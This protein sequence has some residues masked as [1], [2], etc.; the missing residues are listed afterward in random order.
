[1]N[2]PRNG[3]FFTKARLAGCNAISCIPIAIVLFV[4][5]SCA[6]RTTSDLSRHLAT[7]SA[8]EEL[9]VTVKRLGIAR[10]RP[11]CGKAFF[12][13]QAMEGTVCLRTGSVYKGG[14]AE[15]AWNKDN[16]NFCISAD[17]TQHVAKTP[18]F[19]G[20]QE[21]FLGGLLQMATNAAVG[22][23]G[24]HWS[25]AIDETGITFASQL[26]PSMKFAKAAESEITLVGFPSEA[27]IE[28]TLT[29][30][31]GAESTFPHTWIARSLSDPMLWCVLVFDAPGL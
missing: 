24:P 18:S 31:R 11:F 10:D 25:S 13:M 30:W 1:M 27:A 14:I 3:N 6:S 15:L 23:N 17:R 21:R 8:L 2:H 7:S 29:E 20:D 26:Y 22:L 16:E 19:S 28:V 5:A 12:P 9:Q 4:V